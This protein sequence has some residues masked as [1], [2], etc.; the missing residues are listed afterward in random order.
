MEE[1]RKTTTLA[2]PILILVYLIHMCMIGIGRK[3][4]HD[5]LGDHWD[6]E[7]DK[8]ETITRY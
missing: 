8:Y 4:R 7:T 6:R 1:P 2:T 5:N 3:S